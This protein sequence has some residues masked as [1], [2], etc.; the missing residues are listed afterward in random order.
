MRTSR[1]MLETRITKEAVLEV[2]G[3]PLFYCGYC[4]KIIKPFGS[5][6]KGAEKQ[7]IIL[8][9]PRSLGLKSWTA[10]TS[11]CGT[12]LLRAAKTSLELAKPSGARAY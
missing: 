7:V 11:A 1:K 3:Y 5:G 10:W 8:A 4:L 12:I 2:D 6:S 9:L